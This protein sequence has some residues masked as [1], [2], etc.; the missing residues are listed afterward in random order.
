MTRVLFEENQINV[1][2]LVHFVNSDSQFTLKQQMVYIFATT[3][4]TCDVFIAR[5]IPAQH[6]KGRT[7]P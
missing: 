7:M 1:H 4:F 6:R 5:S 3:Y 2:G